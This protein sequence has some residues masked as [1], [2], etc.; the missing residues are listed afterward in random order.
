MYALIIMLMKRDGRAD[1]ASPVLLILLNFYS[2]TIHFS[3][4][5]HLKA[6]LDA[7]FLF[8][9]PSAIEWKNAIEF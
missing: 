5:T 6:F 7:S 8:I 3:N 9:V 1:V 4:K 2:D